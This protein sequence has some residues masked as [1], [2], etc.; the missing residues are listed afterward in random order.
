MSKNKSIV[1]YVAGAFAWGVV[2]KFL[3]AAI[4]FLTIPLLLG[5]FGKEEYGLLTLA[6]AT[7]AYMHLLDMGLN[8]GGIKFFSQWLASGNYNLVYRVARTNIS[9]YLIIG[10]VNSIVLLF[11]ATW[12]RGLFNVTHGEFVTFRYLLY[13]LATFSIVNWITFVFNQLLIADERIAFTQQMASVRSLLGL[14][15]VGATALF[16]WSLI[17]YFVTYV[18]VHASVIFPY[19]YLCKRRKLISSILPAFYWEDF[20]VVFKYGLAILAMAVFQF[21]A[22]HSRPL[23]LA[24]FSSEGVVILTEYRIIEVFPIFI[25]SIGGMMLSIFLPKTSRAIQNNDRRTIERIAYEGTKYTS[26]LVALLCFPIMLSARELLMLY[27]GV[28]YSY[29]SPWLFLWV[30]TLTLSLHNSPVSSLVLAT[31]RTKMLVFSS[32]C[33]CITSVVINMMLT[34][35]YGVG[36]AVIGYLIYII[37]QISFYYLYFNRKVLGLK[38]SKVFKSF[39]IPTCLGLVC[40]VAVYFIKIEIDLLILKI[41]VK[42]IIWGLFYL[43]LLLCF[44]VVEI[45]R[46]VQL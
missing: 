22:T 13:I 15:A 37:I 12:G 4:K 30:F 18:A 44:K 36:S 21:T 20:T 32:A 35:E 25:I 26:I 31:G 40:F 16:K 27:V 46:N 43:L 7:N 23:I 17:Q 42:T 5:Y 28:E 11:I 10:L 14:A 19:I 38:S 3:D 45:K 29:L 33:A 2:T 6:I 1:K 34:R 24:M 41:V 9:F 8:T 39:I